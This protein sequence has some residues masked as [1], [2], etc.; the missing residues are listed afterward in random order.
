[1]HGGGGGGGGGCFLVQWI[2]KAFVLAPRKYLETNQ[3]RIPTP[4]SSR[5]RTIEEARC[6]TMH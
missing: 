4:L 3:P 5:I 2:E 1:M 6:R